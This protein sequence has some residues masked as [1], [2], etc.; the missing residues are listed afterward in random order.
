MVPAREWLAPP[1]SVEIVRA[2]RRSR[3]RSRRAIATLHR[4]TFQLAHGWADIAPYFQL[5]D[6]LAPNLGGGYWGMPSADCY[7]G[8]S[9]RWFVDVWGDHN[10]EVAL[11]AFLAAYNFEAGVLQD[12][13]E[14]PDGPEGVWRDPHAQQLPGAGCGAPAGGPDGERLRLQDRRRRARA[15][16]AAAPARDRSPRPRSVSSIRPSIPI[17]R[18]CWP[19][20]RRRP[21]RLLT[22][23]RD[24]PS[25]APAP[26]AAII[27]ET[28]TEIVVEAEAAVDGFLLLA[29]TFY[30]GW[31]AE[32]DGK[33][34]ALYRANLSVR[35]IQLPKGRHEVRFT[36]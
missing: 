18:C 10:R 28:Q 22:R 6:V 17:A 14:S 33:P 15:V 36:Y 25:G 8:I 4:R 9:P 5:R 21:V 20:R 12:P 27:R 34:V 32:V 30:P 35:A 16:R 26:R 13:A 1:A 23:R 24:A 3:A 31:T 11:M 2:A 19:T 29:D 7:V